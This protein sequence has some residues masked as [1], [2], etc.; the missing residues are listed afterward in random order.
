MAWS[1]HTSALVRSA[2]PRS[3]T[4]YLQKFSF[5]FYYLRGFTTA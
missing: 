4:A 1:V 5:F 2:M 3:N